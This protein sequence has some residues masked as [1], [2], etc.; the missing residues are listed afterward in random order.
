MTRQRTQKIDQ[1]LNRRQ[2]D[3][4]VLLENVHKP[5]NLAAIIRSSDAAGV[6]QVHAIPVASGLPK[7]AH[8]SQGSQK[9]VR[10]IKHETTADAIRH[11]QDSGHNLVAAHFSKQA[12][13]FRELDY[14][15]P[16]AIV[17]GAEKL[18]LSQTM[19]D[20]VDDEIIIPMLGMTPSL[21]VSVAC[22]VILYEA[23]QQRLTAGMYDQRRLDDQT[24]A[25][26]RFEWLHPKLARYCQKHQR[27]Y[28]ALDEAGELLE[29]IPHATR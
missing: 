28:P 20:A 12:V 10:V 17:F 19:L 13:D 22:A 24:W 27:D 18:G 4:T 23:M 21:N 26:S 3:L 9:W 8:T 5:H 7:L 11:L 15:R 16:T 6:H 29:P 1:V 14:T 25:R 2:P